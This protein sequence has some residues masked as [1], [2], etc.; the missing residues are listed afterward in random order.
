M[1]LILEGDEVT[2]YFKMKDELNILRCEI[3]KQKE[4]ID[5]KIT[6]EIAAEP[7]IDSI[8]DPIQDD[9]IKSLEEAFPQYNKKKISE[10][11]Y[12][13]KSVTDSMQGKGDKTRWSNFELDIVELAITD[14]TEIKELAATLPE[15]TMNA[16]LKRIY[17]CGGK[18]VD[19]KCVRDKIISTYN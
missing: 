16:V 9:R 3:E 5:L 18:I 19:S 13:K 11:K 7:V 17:L 14:N 6:S 1:T 4:S 10:N 15:R 12:R 8:V 2:E